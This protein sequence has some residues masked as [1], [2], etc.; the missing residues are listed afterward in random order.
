MSQQ[1]P[2]LGHGKVCYLELPSRDVS[3]SAQFYEKVFNWNIRKRDNGHVSF[4][5]GVLEVSGVW[6]TDR[7]PVIQ[8]G[9]LIYL[10]VDDMEL[11]VKSIVDHGGNI[12]RAVGEDAPEITASF[13]DPTGNVFGL[14]Q[15]RK[16]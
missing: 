10:M 4:D 1:R 16:N 5:D 2:T 11:T 13:S 14:F 15:E 3:E 7:K 8:Q 9:T 12:V 6:R